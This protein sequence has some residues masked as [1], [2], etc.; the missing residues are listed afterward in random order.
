MHRHIPYV[1]FTLPDEMAALAL[2]N[3]VHHIP[4]PRWTERKLDG[5]TRWV[6]L[7]GISEEV[8]NGG[9]N[10]VIQVFVERKTGNGNLW[11]S[12]LKPHS[13][14]D[15]PISERRKGM[16]LQPLTVRVKGQRVEYPPTKS[17]LREAL[18][19][20]RGFGERM[21]DCGEDPRHRTTLSAGRWDEP[22]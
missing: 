12:S 7:S 15:V 6:H 4:K 14:D 22:V 8:T 21:S 16:P 2:A 1:F 18:K 20:F 13:V 3:P 19:Q 17:A 11:G 10:G 9:D 5:R